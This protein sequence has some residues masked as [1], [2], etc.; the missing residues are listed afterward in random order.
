MM[1]RAVLL[2]VLTLSTYIS[3]AVHECKVNEIIG[4]YY[5]GDGV[6]ILDHTISLND[7]N[8]DLEYCADACANAGYGNSTDLIGVEY[9]VQCFCGHTFDTTHGPLKT[10]N[11]SQCNVLKCPGSVPLPGEGKIIIIMFIL[12]WGFYYLL[13]LHGCILSTYYRSRILW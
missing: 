9:G 13:L 2:L 3:A 7:P 11:I 4:C 1:M 10:Y 5:D 12:I 6:R 8:N